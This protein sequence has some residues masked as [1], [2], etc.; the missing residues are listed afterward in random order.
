MF[1]YYF[2]YFYVLPKAYNGRYLEVTFGIFISYAI[3]LGIELLNFKI[4]FPRLNI[5]TLRIDLSFI[6]FLKKN[7]SW[8]YQLL[9]IV[10]T[11]I[12]NQ[13][14]V[15]KAKEFNN[16]KESRLS[17]ELG[18]L[19]NQFHSHL[20][21]N[22][23]SYCH[24]KML[25]FSSYIAESIEDYTEMLK[26]TLQANKSERISIQKEKSYIDNFM[27]LQSKLVNN[28]HHYFDYDTDD[29]SYEVTPLLLGV[30]VEYAYKNGL[31]SS[32]NNP[33]EIQLSVIDYQ[34]KFRIKFANN[35]KPNIDYEKEIKQLNLF[36][37]LNYKNNFDLVTKSDSDLCYISLNINLYGT[38]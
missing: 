20:N 36:L 32:A 4:V 23:L 22:F 15:S 12:L 3:F 10:Y 2:V 21:M 38:Y 37:S 27:Q 8:Y 30:L 1:S 29:E 16:Q 35:W 26:Y 9:I 17:I 7:F 24:S 34:L 14:G 28:I 19:K 33:I 6:E 13:I 5:I 11:N 18:M 31:L 25:K